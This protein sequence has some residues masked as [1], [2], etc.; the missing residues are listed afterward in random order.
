MPPAESARG[1]LHALEV[2][3]TCLTSTTDAL[4][5]CTAAGKRRRCAMAEGMLCFCLPAWLKRAAAAWQVWAPHAL[6]GH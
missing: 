2:D 4:R 5:G 3:W 1:M 6:G